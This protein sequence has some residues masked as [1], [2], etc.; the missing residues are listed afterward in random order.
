MPLAHRQSDAPRAI[1]DCA[2]FIRHD[3]SI[4]L[5]WIGI[6]DRNAE[7]NQVVS[8]AGVLFESDDDSTVAGISTG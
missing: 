3:R 2:D 1:D 4:Q 6:G 7:T 5:L 8:A